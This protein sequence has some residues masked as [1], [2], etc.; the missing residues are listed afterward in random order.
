M[1]ARQLSTV[2]RRK[3]IIFVQNSLGDILFFRPFRIFTARFFL[4]ILH[5]S[6]KLAFFLF[7][8]KLAN[9][10]LSHGANWIQ[11][12]SQ[13]WGLTENLWYN[14]TNSSSSSFFWVDACLKPTISCG[15]D[16]HTGKKTFIKRRKKEK[17]YQ[18]RR[19]WTRLKC[20]LIFLLSYDFLSLIVSNWN[21]SI[22]YI[23]A[24]Y[25]MKCN[26]AQKKS[27]W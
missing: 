7:Y 3:N 16:C 13:M 2:A 17:K 27:V 11:S 14:M 5:H 6:Y 15:L 22:T 21:L 24:Y 20:H 19:R 26:A 23:S 12:R 9:W 1:C 18:T 10:I 8:W 25:T 4:Y